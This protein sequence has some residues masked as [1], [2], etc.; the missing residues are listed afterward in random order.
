MPPILVF[1]TAADKLA[2]LYDGFIIN[3]TAPGAVLDP[4]TGESLTR[5]RIFSS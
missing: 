1:E 3:R 4:V 5:I 2:S